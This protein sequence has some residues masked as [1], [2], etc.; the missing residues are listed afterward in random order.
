MNEYKAILGGLCDTCSRST[1]VKTGQSFFK[2]KGVK[3]YCKADMFIFDKNPC[4][5]YKVK[6]IIKANTALRKIHFQFPA[7]SHG[8]LMYSVIFQAIRDLTDISELNRESARLFL[9][10]DMPQAEICG[11]DAG[12]IR[13]VL[14]KCGVIK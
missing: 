10:G 12:W 8:K 2:Q 7:S 4:N 13:G 14:N 3:Y 6:D 1:S 11:V 9:K 5:F